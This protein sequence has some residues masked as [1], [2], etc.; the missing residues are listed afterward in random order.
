MFWFLILFSLMN[1]NCVLFFIVLILTFDDFIFHFWW[2]WKNI[3]KLRNSL[4]LNFLLCAFIFDWELNRWYCYRQKIL[5]IS[6]HV[7][8]CSWSL[9]FVKYFFLVTL[10]NSINFL[11]YSCDFT[12][13][14]FVTV[15][16]CLKCWVFDIIY[17]NIEL[18]DIIFKFFK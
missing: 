2:L 4:K 12:W 1:L 16:N 11:E 3:H 9:W 7:D 10:V 6:G 17:Q 13:M 15:Y 18:D 8:F 5:V 14:N